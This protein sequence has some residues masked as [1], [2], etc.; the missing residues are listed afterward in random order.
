MMSLNNSETGTVSSDGLSISYEIF[1][2]GYPIVLVHG[3]GSDGQANWRDT[4]WV[5]A[6]VPLRQVVSIDVRGHG[7]SDKPMDAE[8]YTY[9]NMSQDVLSVMDALGIRQADYLG[10]SM[11]AFMGAWL[12]GHATDRFS[13]MILA[14]IGDETDESAAQGALIAEALRGESGAG[15]SY[16]SAVRAFVES[17][18]RNNLD[19]LAWSAATMWPDGYPMKLIGHS[20]GINTPVLIVN[21]EDDFPYVDSADNLADA[22]L[23]AQHVRIRNADHLSCV[24][25]PE[26]KEVVQTFLQNK[27]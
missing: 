12:L 24:T 18:P 5:E 9:A 26:F 16:A 14:G 23:A 21:G 2:T 19:S 27:A 15:G 7:L 6:L 22:L 4:G 20:A 13:A 10:Y 8:S 25:R 11:G 3:W 1:G 17:N